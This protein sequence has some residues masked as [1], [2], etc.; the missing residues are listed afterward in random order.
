MV[1]MNDFK[2]NYLTCKSKCMTNDNLIKM[3]SIKYCKK[4]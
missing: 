1:F 4:S 3:K 2:E